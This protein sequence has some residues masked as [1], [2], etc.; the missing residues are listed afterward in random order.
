[1][2]DITVHKIRQERLSSLKAAGNGDFCGG[3]LRC[4]RSPGL[5]RPVQSK[6]TGV[7][8]EELVGSAASLS[9][10]GRLDSEVFSFLFGDVPP[11]GS[12]S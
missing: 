5:W 8:W 9:A 7:D 12:H 3:V 1:M 6:P 11:S 2:D 4:G 10:E